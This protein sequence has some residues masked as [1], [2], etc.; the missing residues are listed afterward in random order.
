MLTV[1]LWLPDHNPERLRSK[2]NWPG[3]VWTLHRTLQGIR[4]SCGR[5][6]FQRVCHSCIQVR[7]RHHLPNPQQTERELPGARALPPPETSHVFLQSLDNSQRRSVHFF[8]FWKLSCWTNKIS[9]KHIIKTQQGGESA[10]Y[11]SAAGSIICLVV[12]PGCMWCTWAGL[13]TY[14]Y[15]QRVKSGP[16]MSWIIHDPL[17][18]DSLEKV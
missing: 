12:R 2:D 6:S 5:L 11:G 17:T 10:L 16:K 3:V 8:F 14:F 13:L 7:P 1:H 15:L 4:S 9:C 18:G